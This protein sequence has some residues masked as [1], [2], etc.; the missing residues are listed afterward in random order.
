MREVSVPPGVETQEEGRHIWEYQK[1]W[2]VR[3]ISRFPGTKILELASDT[4]QETWQY[5][6]DLAGLLHAG[7]WNVEGPRK[8]PHSYDGMFDLQVSTDNAVRPEAAAL[9][10]ALVR[11]GVK[12]HQGALPDPD[13]PDGLLVMFVGSRSPVSIQPEDCTKVYFD[14]KK[15]KHHPCEM[16]RQLS[17][18]GCPIVPFAGTAPQISP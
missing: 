17:G 4:G 14:A 9:M 3:A 7:G 6:R 1:M 18:S 12:H 13:I 11:S 5:A 10:D 2:I 15:M 8:L 16:F